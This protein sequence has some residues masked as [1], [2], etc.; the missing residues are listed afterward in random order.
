[1]STTTAA[2]R[3]QDPGPLDLALARAE[4]DAATAARAALRDR[5]P[6]SSPCCQSRAYRDGT[7]GTW[8]C[9]MCGR[10][11]DV[12]G[13][14]AVEEEA[15]VREATAAARARVLDPVL[16]TLRRRIAT[17]RDRD[18]RALGPLQA[19]WREYLLHRARPDRY[20]RTAAMREW[21]DDRLLDLAQK[22]R[23]NWPR[24][25]VRAPRAGARARRAV[26]GHGPVD[27][28]RA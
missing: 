4:V 2:P 13:P 9:G 8:R 18:R 25:P 5:A 21:Q 12:P 20:P 6:A 10:G 23:A 11:F 17:E 19:A 15:D 28:R 1:M 7:A 27:A 24:R 14:S 22:H 26:P 16:D 3:W